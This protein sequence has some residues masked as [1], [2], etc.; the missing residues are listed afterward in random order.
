MNDP[1]YPTDADVDLLHRLL[2]ADH[3]TGASSIEDIVQQVLCTFAT[4]AQ[5]GTGVA[6]ALVSNSHLT[7]D[8]ATP[9][10]IATI[11]DRAWTG[12][13]MPYDLIAERLYTHRRM[14]ALHF[15]TSL[16]VAVA[17]NGI[18]DHDAMLQNT[19][20][21]VLM[22]LSGV[23]DNIMDKR[24]VKGHCDPYP[25]AWEVLAHMSDQLLPASNGDDAIGISIAYFLAHVLLCNTT[26]FPR[27]VFTSHPHLASVSCHLIE[28]LVSKKMSS[29]DHVVFLYSNRVS[30]RRVDKTLDIVLQSG[31]TLQSVIDTIW[32][33]CDG[34]DPNL[35]NSLLYLQADSTAKE[36]LSANNTEVVPEITPNTSLE[37]SG[38]NLI[39][40]GE[41][42]STIKSCINTISKTQY[43]FGDLYGSFMRKSLPA[44]TRSIQKK[45]VKREAAF[46]AMDCVNP[47][48]P[49]DQTKLRSK[50]TSFEMPSNECVWMPIT[51]QG[52]PRAGDFPHCFKSRICLSAHE[53]LLDVVD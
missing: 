26:Y 12:G 53:K 43:I 16:L 50:H 42:L 17:R 32:T 33:N 1:K 18:F 6:L 14:H 25:V 28:T 5:L 23:S 40:N 9:H 37:A 39:V 49:K 15:A 35:M 34:L 31:M 19:Y 45:Y 27:R 10:L 22:I 24:V 13:E 11:L 2:N 36:Q 46:K 7:L 47:T 29:V 8:R 44:S 48:T 3:N 20:L 41:G 52:T 21:T 30:V 51:T 38:I 4:P